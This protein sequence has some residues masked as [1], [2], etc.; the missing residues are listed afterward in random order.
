MPCARLSQQREY[1]RCLQPLSACQ[2]TDLRTSVQT[3]EKE[4]IGS[5]LVAER[6]PEMLVCVSMCVCIYLAYINSR[7]QKIRSILLLICSC[8]QSMFE[9]QICFF[10]VV[11]CY[12]CCARI[13]KDSDFCSRKLWPFQC[14]A[15]PESLQ[16]VGLYEHETCWS[17]TTE[18]PFVMS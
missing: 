6:Y 17:I 13:S 1:L 10:K 7:I 14:L 5:R 15:H 12:W 8:P 2:G 18:F 9:S 16:L 4:G 3:W 11:I